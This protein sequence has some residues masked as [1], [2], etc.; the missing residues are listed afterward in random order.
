M[1]GRSSAVKEEPDRV[2]APLPLLGAVGSTMG[3]ASQDDSVIDPMIGSPVNTPAT[4]SITEGARQQEKYSLLGPIFTTRDRQALESHAWVKDLLK[5]FSS[6]HWESI[7][8]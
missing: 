2:G 4:A 1:S 8:Q 7:C 6:R 5:D 3:G